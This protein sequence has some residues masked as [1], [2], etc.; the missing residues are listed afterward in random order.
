MHFTIYFE[1]A[2]SYCYFIDIYL[3]IS[4]IA[5]GQLLFKEGTDVVGKIVAFRNWLFRTRFF[6]SEPRNILYSTFVR[7]LVFIHRDQLS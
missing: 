5:R 3:Y 1:D 7:R 6:C 2:L 4:F